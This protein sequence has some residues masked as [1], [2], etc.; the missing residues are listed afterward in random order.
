[1][2]SAK[3]KILCPVNALVIRYYLI[4]LPSFTLRWEDFIEEDLIQSFRH[5]T[6]EEKKPLFSKCFRY[7]VSLTNQRFP[8]D[9]NMFNE[10]TKLVISMLSQLLGIYK[11]MFVPA[12]L[13]SMLFK[14]SMSQSESQ[15]PQPPCLKFD[16]FLAENI[17]S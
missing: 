5:V 7:D 11:D 9:V 4:I 16:E 3:T 8:L 6:I 13:I 2:D 12:L 14:V 10:E 1:M 17:H 15:S